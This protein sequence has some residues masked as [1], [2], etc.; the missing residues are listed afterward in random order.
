MNTSRTRLAEADI[1]EIA[2]YISQDNPNAAIRWLDTLE[3]KFETIAEMPG[4]G[5]LRGY[6][7]PD[8][9]SLAFGNYLIF[10]HE[11]DA[12]IEILRVLHGARQWEDLL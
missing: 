3:A 7:R 5:I 9:R 10:Y 2:I 1:E 12:G 11:I 6:I 8:L 4:M